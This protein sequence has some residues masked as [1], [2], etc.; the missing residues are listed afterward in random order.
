MT[1]LLALSLSLLLAQ[2]Y[3]TG[4]TAPAPDMATVRDLYASASYEEALTRLNSLERGVAVEQVEQYRAL[5]LL[6]LGRTGDAERALERMVIAKPLYKIEGAD[7]S[8][9]LISMFRE[10]RQRLLPSTARELYERGTANFDSKH[11]DDAAANFQTLISL[12][13]D[14]DLAS[15][16]AMF[17]DMR[18]LS[19]GFLKLAKVE[20]AAAEEARA[21]AVAAARAAAEAKAAAAAAPPPKTVFSADDAEVVPPVELERH[22]PAWNPPTQLA[23]AR[24]YSGVLEIV[25]DEKGRVER[26]SL[27]RSVAP[28]YDTQLLEMATS[29]KFRPAMRD[30]QP[31][32]YVKTFE[33][34][35]SRP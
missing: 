7:I 16:S 31:V 28:F 22:M 21:K 24:E 5:C 11:F 1:T 8:P 15:Q 30:G 23:A 12:L 14:D 32:K 4:A 17:A 6:G 26:A 3:S 25:V 35:R 2:D 29:W 27:L 13:D 10:V 20:I 34:V 19:D 18:R 33:I 9:R